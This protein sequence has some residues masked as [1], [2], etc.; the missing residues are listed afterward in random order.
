MNHTS[1]KTWPL[2]DRSRAIYRQNAGIPT[3]RDEAAPSK[4]TKG[5][6]KGDHDHINLFY[7]SIH[8]I[9]L[10]HI[11]TLRHLF[12]Y[13]SYLI[14]TLPSFLSSPLL[15]NY[16]QHSPPPFKGTVIITHIPYMPYSQNSLKLKTHC[17]NHL[18]NCS[19]KTEPYLYPILQRNVK[20]K[21][22]APHGWKRRTPTWLIITSCSSNT[23][24]FLRCCTQ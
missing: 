19:E 15:Y 9:Y 5:Y 23:L 1:G 21:K 24:F 13:L 2:P 16:M 17:Q 3:A 8:F 18:L 4:K 7:T 20:K 10:K 6:N 22:G 14:Q 12:P 11:N